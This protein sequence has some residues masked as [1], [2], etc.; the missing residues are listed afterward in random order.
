MEVKTRKYSN[1]ENRI[2]TFAKNIYILLYYQYMVNLWRYFNIQKTINHQ[3]LKHLPL[4]E[5]P[6]TVKKILCNDV[7]LL[8]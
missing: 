3:I 5:H 6:F 1:F 4:N 7:T 2:Y 8:P